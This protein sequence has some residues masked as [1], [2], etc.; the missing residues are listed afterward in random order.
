[1]HKKALSICCYK[2]NTQWLIR[3][4]RIEASVEVQNACQN[5]LTA[6][7]SLYG[8]VE[9]T[10]QE[11]L[12]KEQLH[13]NEVDRYTREIERLKTEIANKE[14]LSASS[15]K[16]LEVSRFELHVEVETL[17][18]RIEGLKEDQAV[19]LNKMTELET[20]VQD[21]RGQ[22]ASAEAEIE[23]LKRQ[24]DSQKTRLEDEMAGLSA[25]FAQTFH[26]HSNV[27]NL[28][29]AF[30]SVAMTLNG[31]HGRIEGLELRCMEYEHRISCLDSEI[32]TV[33]FLL[34]F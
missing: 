11:I 14:K 5:K 10:K 16:E 9:R 13:L 8:E 34:N 19:M 3:P 22:R 18:S 32:V 27:D 30:T 25:R 33:T 17:H 24:L 20:L 23:S 15:I 26:M 28:E 12:S 4:F 1:M 29:E 31:C 2:G 21:L 6:L 7:D